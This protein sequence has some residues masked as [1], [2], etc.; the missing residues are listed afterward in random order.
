MHLEMS[1]GISSVSQLSHTVIMNAVFL[2]YCKYIIRYTHT[3]FHMIKACKNWQYTTPQGG[4]GM[5]QESSLVFQVV[6][7]NQLS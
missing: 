4:E 6:Q 1:I 3:C 5:N 7:T 2:V